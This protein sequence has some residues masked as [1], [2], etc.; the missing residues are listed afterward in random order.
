MAVMGEIGPYHFGLATEAAPLQ[1]HEARGSAWGARQYAVALRRLGG[2]LGDPELADDG[3]PG[4]LGFE[5]GGVLPQR[6]G[7]DRET[8]VG[9]RLAAVARCVDLG[10]AAAPAR[11]RPPLLPPFG[12]LGRTPRPR[13]VPAP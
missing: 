2:G 5:L 3:A 6:C 9:C 11:R 8:S 7:R 1:R 12:I 4:G 13:P 10:P